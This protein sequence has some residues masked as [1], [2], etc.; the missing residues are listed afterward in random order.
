[1]LALVTCEAVLP[2]FA[3]RARRCGAVPCRALRSGGLL[4]RWQGSRRDFAL[5]VSVAHGG[6]RRHRA[7]MSTTGTV[8]HPARP[9]NDGQRR[10]R[11]SA[12][13][14][15]AM[16]AR[17]LP[18]LPCARPRGVAEH[19]VILPNTGHSPVLPANLYNRFQ[20]GTRGSPARRASTARHGTAHQA[21]W[22]GHYK[23]AS[24]FA[25]HLVIRTCC[26]QTSTTVL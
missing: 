23:T 5:R 11:G 24:H 7:R 22:H 2:W 25:Q 6:W 19:L 10:S 26:R 9:G 14:A 4:T 3:A 13:A 20:H 17:R 12:L 18:R 15:T 16:H 21:C 1:M 8:V